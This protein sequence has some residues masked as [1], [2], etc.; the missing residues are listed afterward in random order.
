MDLQRN[1]KAKPYSYYRDQ[2][3]AA[4]NNYIRAIQVLLKSYSIRELTAA[5]KDLDYRHI[6]LASEI[7]SAT[8]TDIDVQCLYELRSLDIAERKKWVAYIRRYKPT[9]L[10]LRNVIHKARKQVSHHN[11]RADQSLRVQW[12]AERQE[13]ALVNV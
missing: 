12:L 8:E 13:R 2:Y 10:Q 6:R 3:R 5:Y 1:M 4:F 9:A 11:V 7:S